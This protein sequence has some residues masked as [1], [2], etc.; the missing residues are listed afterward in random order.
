M[1][2]IRSGQVVE[3]GSPERVMT[4][5]TLREVFAIDADI[6]LEPR[7]GRPVYVTYQL[8]PERNQDQ[9]VAQKAIAT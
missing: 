3:H 2:A 5:R 7:T 1:V 4:A 6:M 8:L 9:Q